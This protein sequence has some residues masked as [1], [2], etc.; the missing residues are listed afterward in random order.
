MTFMMTR[1]SIPM[2]CIFSRTWTQDWFMLACSSRMTITSRTSTYGHQADITR[3]AGACFGL[4][5]PARGKPPTPIAEKRP[6]CVKGD[7][8]AKLMTLLKPWRGALPPTLTKGFPK[9]R[10][11]E[12]P[13]VILS[14]SSLFWGVRTKIIIQFWSTTTETRTHPVPDQT[15][16]MEW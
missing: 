8:S 1:V 4:A 10:F 16:P 5:K 3:R 14:P 12:M 9:W 11:S 15:A 2:I 6:P 7:V 13:S